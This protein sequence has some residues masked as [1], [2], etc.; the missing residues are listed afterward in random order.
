MEGPPHIELIEGG[1]TG[2]WS[3]AG[4]P[5]LDHIGFWSDDVASDKRELAGRGLPIDVDGESLGNPI[6]TYHSAPAC[7]MRVELVSSE[8]RERFYAG[9]ER[10][11]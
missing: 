11:R 6:F 5:R 7:G 3:S 9:L 10:A 1:E 8:V 4:G 2:P